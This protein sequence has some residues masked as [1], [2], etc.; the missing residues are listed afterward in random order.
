MCLACDNPASFV[1]LRH[2]FFQLPIGVV[3][4]NFVIRLPTISAYH[5]SGGKYFLDHA[6]ALMPRRDFAR[7][8][9]ACI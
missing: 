5:Q 4:S 7:L 8:A 9:V 3:G 1:S 6:C 2:A